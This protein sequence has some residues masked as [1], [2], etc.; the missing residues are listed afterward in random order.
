VIPVLTYPNVRD[1]VAWLCA[2]FGF[3]ERVRIGEDHRAQLSV[4]P[5]IQV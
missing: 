2:S 4:E 1:A 5:P 3:L